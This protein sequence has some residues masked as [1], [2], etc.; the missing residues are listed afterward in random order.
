MRLLALTC[1]LILLLVTKSMGQERLE[2]GG[3]LGGSG[4]LGDLNKSDW[5]SKEPKV[6]LGSLVRY[7]VS[8]F[9]AVRASLLFGHLSGRDSHYED[10]AFR[11]FSTQSPISEMAFQ[12]EL[13]V[14]PLIQ[15]R[16]P[17][18]F[19]STF[20][21]FIFVGLGGAYTRPAPDLE[22][23]IVSKPE[24]VIGAEIDQNVVY[25]H[26]HV[27]VPF[28]MGI[29]YRPHIHWTLTLE[30][31]FRLTF[32]DYLDGISYAANPD[33]TDRYQFWGL[34]VAYRLPKRVVGFRNRNPLRC[35]TNP[36]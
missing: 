12:A 9:L 13:H 18:F 1:C 25:S 4:Y 26:Y 7:N 20:S 5:I 8:D 31:G 33:K 11:N 36:Y 19:Q 23:M 3:F 24:F 30:A 16:L 10:R 2:F 29:K 34:T 17:R 22:N 6:G 14:L 27:I 21:P 35:T 15:P 32:S 28:G